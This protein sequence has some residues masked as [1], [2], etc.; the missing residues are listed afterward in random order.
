MNIPTP[1]PHSFQIAHSTLET[2]PFQRAIDKSQK[3]AN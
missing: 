3:K 2:I 1:Y